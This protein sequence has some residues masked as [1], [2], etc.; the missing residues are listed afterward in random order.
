MRILLLISLF[1]VS[2]AHHRD[3][4][5]SASGKHRVIL[6]TENNTSGYNNAKGQADH[7]CETEGKRA[8]IVK[9]GHKYTGSLDEET[10]KRGKLAS[11]VAKGVGS[12]GFVF[13]G[14][15]EKTAGGIVGLGGQVADSAIGTGYT[16]TML[17]KCK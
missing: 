16:Y 12:A 2:C 5:P 6:Q 11:K 17:F 13:G 4:R 3:V 1:I 8:Y 14:K 7:F 9:E 15:R 10:Y